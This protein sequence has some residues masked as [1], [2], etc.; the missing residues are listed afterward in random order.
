MSYIYINMKTKLLHHNNYGP[1]PPGGYP[2][3]LKCN[4]DAMEFSLSQEAA[5]DLNCSLTGGATTCAGQFAGL[6]ITKTDANHNQI[7]DDRY[8]GTSDWAFNN[9][10]FNSVFYEQEDFIDAT[11]NADNVQ[12]LNVV[13]NYMT[14]NYG[15]YTL[16]FVS[17][18]YTTICGTET[19]EM[20]FTPTT[21]TCKTGIEEEYVSTATNIYPNP[22]SDFLNLE[23]LSTDENPLVTIYSITGKKVYE[24][25]LNN[26]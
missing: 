21:A 25:S 17:V 9:G 13:N 15:F 3:F 10:I 19:A 18:E 8:V 23:F 5:D 7:D 24:K 11:A 6:T 2:T 20:W 12:L 16:M 14:N 22:A 4:G 1:V 26:N